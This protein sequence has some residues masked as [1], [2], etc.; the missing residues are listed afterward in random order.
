MSEDSMTE[1]TTA[2]PQV[3]CLLLMWVLDFFFLEKIVYLNIVC[4]QVYVILEASPCGDE[5][6]LHVVGCPRT[7][8]CP[9]CSSNTSKNLLF[10]FLL[11]RLLIIFNLM[12][13]NYDYKKI[14]LKK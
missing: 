7:T 14:S 9:S 13:V 3:R 2:A 8:V 10:Y 12:H 5:K 6:V 4:M 11:D 1:T